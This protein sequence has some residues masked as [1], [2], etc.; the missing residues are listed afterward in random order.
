MQVSEN[1]WA[2]VVR[3]LPK[4]IDAP[5]LAGTRVAT[6]SAKNESAA[7]IKTRCADTPQRINPSS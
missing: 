7:P 3:S 5:E 6:V 4:V 1:P 2:L